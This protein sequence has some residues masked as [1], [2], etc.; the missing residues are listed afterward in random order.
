MKTKETDK[1]RKDFVFEIR[2]AWE[3]LKKAKN[4]TSYWDKKKNYDSLVEE[5]KYYDEQHGYETDLEEWKTK[6]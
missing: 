6:E 1:A 5:L 2:V 4:Y 3:E